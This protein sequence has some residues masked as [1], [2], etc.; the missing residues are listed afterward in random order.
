[1]DNSPLVISFQTGAETPLIMGG[2]VLTKPATEEILEGLDHTVMH[3]VF[4]AERN[5]TCRVSWTGA[6]KLYSILRGNPECQTEP[7]EVQMVQG[8]RLG[9]YP[10]IEL[11]AMDASLPPLNPVT[12][13]LEERP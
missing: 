6:E 9:L 10:V 11:E 12:I 8:Q 5:L 2:N 1:M 4:E 7:F 13:H 3:G